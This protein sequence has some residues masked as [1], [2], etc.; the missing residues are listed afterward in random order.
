VYPSSSGAIGCPSNRLANAD[1]E[2]DS[3]EEVIAS[4]PLSRFTTSSSVAPGTTAWRRAVPE[5][6]TETMEVKETETRWV[7][8]HQSY[9]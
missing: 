6:Q 1:V 8:N 7:N 5:N 4:P 3:D 2:R 9:L